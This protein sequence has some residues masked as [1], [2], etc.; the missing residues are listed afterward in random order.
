MNWKGIAGSVIKAAPII[1]GILGGPAAGAGVKVAANLISSVLGVEPEPD[2][3]SR[4]LQAN[5]E[6]LVEIRKAEMDNKAE[7]TRLYLEAEA[8]E[9]AQETQRI[10]AV[11]ATMQAE[12]KSEKWPQYWWRP[13]IGFCTGFAF[14][15]LVLFVA[16]L[17]CMAI[18]K[19]QPQILNTIP[20]LVASFATLFAIP[21]GILGVSAWHR[22]RKQR[23]AAGESM[24]YV[25]KIVEAIKK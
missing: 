1:G 22:G 21:G 7:L 6:A 25:G 15:I 13:F 8:H 18:G 9:M 3:I 11:N 17:C 12:A 4:A 24:G 23:A 5:P 2:K 20:G 10:L 16:I 14:L 19:N